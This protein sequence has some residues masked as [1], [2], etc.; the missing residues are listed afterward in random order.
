M[1]AGQAMAHGLLGWD[2]EAKFST[3]GGKLKSERG[4]LDLYM[5]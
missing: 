5:H 4:L 1:G 3:F 2:K